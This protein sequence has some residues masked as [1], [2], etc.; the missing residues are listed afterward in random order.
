M[1][2]LKSISNYISRDSVTYAKIQVLRIKSKTQLLET[3][4]LLGKIMAELENDRY[5]ELIDGNYRIIYKV[6][7][8]DRVDIL[9][10]HHAARDLTRR[11][12]D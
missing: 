1:E 3:T 5:R 11:Q 9:T 7:S 4:P 10:I 6:V 2:D 8:V 12:V